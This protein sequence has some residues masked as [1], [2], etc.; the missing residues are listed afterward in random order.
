M[1]SVSRRVSTS[2]KC[3]N[4]SSMIWLWLPRVWRSKAERLNSWWGHM[5]RSRLV[6]HA[7]ADQTCKKWNPSKQNPVCYGSVIPI[8]SAPAVTCAPT[9]RHT[10]GF[11]LNLLEQFKPQS[12][13]WLSKSREFVVKTRWVTAL[14]GCRGVQPWSINQYDTFKFFTI[15]LATVSL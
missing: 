14:R 3:P 11:Y 4:K 13:V 5:P 8:K 7:S 10:A 9:A 15:I 6:C 2:H 12:K 1:Q